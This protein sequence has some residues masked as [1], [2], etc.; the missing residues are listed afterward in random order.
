MTKPRQNIDDY[1]DYSLLL[2]VFLLILLGFVAIFIATG[3]DYPDRL[4][5]VM[6]QQVAWTL[7]GLLS[8]FVTMFFSTSFLWKSSPFLYLLG[9]GLMVLPLVF[10]SPELVAATGAKNWVT[11]ANT[12]LFQPSEFMKIAYIVMLSVVTVWYQ[13]RF[14]NVT[15]KRDIGLLLCYG[16]LTAPVLV[17]LALQGD[18][19]TAL[20]FLAILSGMILLSAIS[21][22]LILPCLVTLGLSLGAFLL[23]FTREGGKDWLLSVGMD[24]YQINRISAWL[25]P[26]TYSDGIAYQ[27]TQGMISIGS[28]GFSGKGFNVLDLQVPV[29]ESDMIFTV[30]G[31]NFGFLGGVVL[32]TL[33]L[34]LIYRM[35][36]VTL[37]SNNRFYIYISTGFIMMILFHIFENIGAAVGI[38]P[39]TGIPLP[40]VSQGGSS[41]VSNLIGVGLVLSMSFQQSR[42]T[43]KA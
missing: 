27:Q 14:P 4:G 2:P 40:F 19:G 10:F 30:I 11:L 39:L 32:L 26:F 20:V 1:I 6:A 16:A 37:A 7:I 29:R 34:L 23:V 31:E 33:Y 43:E 21:W 35:L 36:R 17:L 5:V 41:L 13:E 38:L 22:K 9:L 3:H 12:T 28:G 24:T 18:L 8:A 25:D 15:W 42:L